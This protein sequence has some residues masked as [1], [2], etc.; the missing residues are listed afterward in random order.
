MVDNRHDF[1]NE[2]FRNFSEN[3]NKKI[4]TT[5][6]CSNGF[7]ER[8]NAITAE[9]TRE[10][11]DDIKCS[12]DMELAWALSAKNYLQNKHVFNPNKLVEI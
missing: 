2:D 7:V 9:A 3:L 8:H 6:A 5:V 4:K 11:K 10:T 1:D 12:L